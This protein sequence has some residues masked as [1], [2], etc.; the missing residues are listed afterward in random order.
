M[1]FED[2]LWTQ[3]KENMGG[4]LGDIFFIP[5]EDVDPAA[6]P[7]L[8]VDGI[9]LTGEIAPLS[10]KEF[11]QIYHTK[12]TGKIDD[13][14]GGE[15]DGKSFENLLEFFFPGQEKSV[16]NFKKMVANTPGLWI[17]KDPQGNYRALGIS[18]IGGVVTL[19]RPA[20]CE[21]I[22]SGTGAA[23]TDKSGSTFQVKSE[24]PHPPLFYSGTIPTDPVV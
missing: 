8:D 3:G 1:A 4:L 24:A 6:L 9:S 11:F 10:T 21:S 2:L 13:N 22:A 12:G 18:A 19:D 20:Y 16:E 15:R 7:T 5:I 14:T 23:S 17:A